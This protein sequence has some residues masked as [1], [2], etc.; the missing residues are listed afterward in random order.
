MSDES[1]AYELGGKKADHLCDQD[2]HRKSDQKCH[3]RTSEVLKKEHQKKL[4]PLHAHHD[5]YAELVRS[6][7]DLIFTCEKDQGKND[8]ECKPIEHTD[9][10]KEL[11][12]RLAF[13]GLQI[14][15]HVL[16]RQ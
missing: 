8:K 16:A 12:D 3:H 11:A 1:D 14:P 9:H 6:S 15:H 10:G 7:L 5:V 13:H 4:G 2:R